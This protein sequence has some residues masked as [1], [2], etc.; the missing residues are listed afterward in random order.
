VPGTLYPGLHFVVPL[1]EDVALFDT[2]DQ[3]FTTGVSEDGKNAAASVSSKSQLLDTQAKEGLTLG[4]AITVR[5][6]LDP[7][8][9]DYIQGNL[10][11][12]VEKEIV[13]P[14]VASVW[15]EL[16]PNYTVRDVFLGQSGRSPA[17]GGGQDHAEAGGRR[18]RGETE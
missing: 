13:P 1:V 3:V 6:R 16:V 11:R 2:R 17:E 8:R 15:R 18:N 9:P 12:P 4:L 14:I 5:Y 7:E 10:P